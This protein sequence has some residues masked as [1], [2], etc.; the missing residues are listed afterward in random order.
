MLKIAV[1]TEIDPYSDHV[2][3]VIAFPDKSNATYHGCSVSREL[4][5]KIGGRVYAVVADY[6]TSSTFG[7]TSGQAQVL[8]VFTTVEEA[9][10]LADAAKALPEDDDFSSRYSFTH[11]GV[12]YYRPWVG[13][14]EELRSLDIWDVQVLPHPKDPIKKGSGRYSLKRGR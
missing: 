7:P 2:S 13:H 9:E 14:F 6:T 8:D 5:V 1:S 4:D 3:N 12:Q 11:N 10:A